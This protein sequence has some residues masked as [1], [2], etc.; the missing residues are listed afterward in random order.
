MDPFGGSGFDDQWDTP[1]F[2]D[3]DD[4]DSSWGFEDALSGYYDSSSP[5]GIASSS[6]AKKSIAQERERRKKFNEKLYTLRSLVPSITKMDKA[7]IVKDAIDYIVELQ[8]E[9]RRLLT[10][11]SELEQENNGKR[12]NDP[13]RCDP[14]NQ[15]AGKRPRLS[16]GTQSQMGS[17]IN[18]MELQVS[19]VGDEACVV[20]ITCSRKRNTMTRLCQALELLPLDILAANITSF[21]GKV[22]HTLL[23]ETHGVSGTHMKE[24]INAAL[25]GL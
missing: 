23:L 5:D 4:L 24:T 13:G 20:S 19:D 25:T 9:E 14:A 17:P 15:A 1:F 16:P 10:E 18:V 12:R 11:I 2:F 22:L 21:S 6:A 8:E 7:S 3:T